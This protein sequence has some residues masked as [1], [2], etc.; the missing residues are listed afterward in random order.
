MLSWY[1]LPLLSVSVKE[2]KGIF[3][4]KKKRKEFNQQDV[5]EWRIEEKK[6]KEKER[7]KKIYFICL[8]AVCVHTYK[9]CEHCPTL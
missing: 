5:V 2:R 6:E 1:Q 7:E 9:A 8:N 4:K 3:K